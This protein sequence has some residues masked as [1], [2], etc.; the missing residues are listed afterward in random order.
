MEEQTADI[1]EP[2]VQ[3]P[4]ES[5]TTETVTDDVV[6]EEETS[7]EEPVKEEAPSESEPEPVKQEEPV[8]KEEE[9]PFVERPGV[10]E[11]L[12]EIEEKYGSKA[13]YW[14]TITEISQQDPEFRIAVLEKLEAAGRI[15]KG[16]VESF[17]KKTEVRQE[18][19]E[20]INSLPEDVRADLI[21]ARQL[22]MEREQQAIRERTAAEKFFA[23][24]ERTRPEI[25]S[26][27]NPVRT[28]N[29]IFTLA[30]ELVERNGLEF[31]AAMDQAYK[32]VVRGTNTQNEELERTIQSNKE[33]ASAI[34]PSV[35]NASGRIR[36]LTQEEKRAAELAGMTPEEYVKYKD[37][38][39]DDLFETL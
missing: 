24:F 20:Y 11:R 19:D 3:A 39:E 31:E 1:K 4:V 14:D 12:S 33:N 5:Q 15:P 29:L 30:S 36:K 27:P 37:S 23:E 22:R 18:S 21:A 26:S 38:S 9:I 16:T 17:K 32:T 2:E 13:E 25:A 8:K 10:K 6:A 34:A 7:V 28:R 35:S